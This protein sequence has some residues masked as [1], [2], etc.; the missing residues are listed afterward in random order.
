MSIGYSIGQPVKAPGNFDVDGDLTVKTD[1][2]VAD[3]SGNVEANGYLDIEDYLDVSSDAFL[4]SGGDGTASVGD[5]KVTMDAT[6]GDMAVAGALA[7][8]GAITRRKASVVAVTAN[9]SVTASQTG[10]TF[11]VT[12]GSGVAFTLP[13]AAAGLI[14]DFANMVN[15]TMTVLSDLSYIHAHGFDK[16]Q[17]VEFSGTAK[18][19]AACRA[20][21]LADAW[22][23][24]NT[25]DLTMTVNE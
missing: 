18:I 11:V 4:V 17:S 12:G 5:G 14:F 10:T 19:G 23:V 22:L 8:S 13:A 15:Q 16:G 6:T 9:T 25:S 7:V 20:I 2:F 3:A 1:K 21:A 24:T